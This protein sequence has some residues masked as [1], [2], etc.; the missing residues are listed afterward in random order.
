MRAMPHP[1]RYGAAALVALIHALLLLVLVVGL[2]P[3]VRQ[4]IGETLQVFDVTPA[5]Q[6]PTPEPR[7]ALQTAPRKEGAASTANV[8]AVATPVVAPPPEVPPPVRS[9]IDAADRSS[10]LEGHEPTAG[11]TELAGPGT[12]SGGSG[13][14]TGSGSGGLGGGGGGAASRA[15]RE[16]GR[17][18]DADYPRAALQAGREG[19]TVVRFTVGTD[20]RVRNCRVTRSSGHSDLDATTCRLIEQRFRYRPA[21]NAA[22]EPVEEEVSRTFDWLLPFRRSVS[23][24]EP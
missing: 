1:S 21:R 7:P 10:P 16:S 14:G 9:P 12:G 22:G 6:P 15:Q 17:I 5:P 20:G 18:S 11:N 4:E 2:S 24:D 19:T 13:Q 23:S 8:Q 3:A